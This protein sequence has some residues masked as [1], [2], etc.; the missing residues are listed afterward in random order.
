MQQKGVKEK[1][2]KS[3]E[4][5][6][7]N[8]NIKYTEVRLVGFDGDQLG[9]MSTKKAFEIARKDD[10]DLVVIAEK[11][12]PP[13]VKIVNFSKYKYELTKR[14]KEQAKKIRESQVEIKEISVRLN[15]DIHDQQRLIKRACE[16]IEEGCKVKINMKFKGRENSR[17]NEGIIFLTNFSNS[18]TNA[19]VEGKINESGKGLTVTLC[20]L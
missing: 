7:V 16:W 9:I 4:K 3:K 11:S 5:H 20:K 2:M 17:K 15:T 10:L 18:I 14:A 13:V 8:E 6:I 12:T 1:L 19:K